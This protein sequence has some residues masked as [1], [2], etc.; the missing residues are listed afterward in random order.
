VS[1][2]V[3]GRA[4]NALGGRRWTLVDRAIAASLSQL[5]PATNESRFGF[6]PPR[7]D[8]VLL[9]RIRRDYRRFSR[10]VR[11][12]IALDRAGA[13]SKESK[14]FLT[15]AIDA[16]NDLGLRTDQLAAT[17]RAQT[18]ALISQNRRSFASSR[19]L[20]VGVGAASIILALLLG[21][22][23]SWS[24][25]RPIQRTEERLAEIAA[26]DFSRHVE[27]P[28]RDE[29]GSL[30]V[31]LNRMNDELRR[32]YEELETASRHKSEFL[33]NMSHGDAGIGA[34][35]GG[36]RLRELR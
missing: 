3:G 30:A 6:V 18:D 13:P 15:V 26:G 22:I 4:S 34:R 1:L 19:N 17:T 25:I 5:G 16:D 29:L 21:F 2:Y 12:I 10:T 8:K 23:I 35:G 7:E 27:V 20:F 36:R 24:L 31:N 9:N 28:N 32:L 33:A 11:R 14:P